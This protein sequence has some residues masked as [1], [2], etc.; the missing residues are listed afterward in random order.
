MKYRGLVPKLILTLSITIC[1]T[2]FIV[3]IILSSLF[4][5]EYYQERLKSLSGEAEV[6]EQVVNSYMKNGST[7][8]ELNKS[9]K[10][11][12]N[13]LNVDIYV[14]DGYGYIYSISNDEYEYLKYTKVDDTEMSS[15]REGK[16]I[17]QKDKKEFV[18]SKPIFN[19]GFFIGAV[20]I[21]TPLSVLSSSL[22]RMN[23]IVWICVAIAIIF[24]S[25][26]IYFISKRIIIKPLNVIN[27]AAKKIANGEIGNRVNLSYDDEVGELA[28]SF[29]IMATSLEEAELNRR[30]FISNVSHELRSPMTSI[31]GFITAILDGVIPRDKEG[32]YLNIVNDEIGRLTRLIN[33]LLDLSAMQAGKLEFNI[34]ELELNRIIETTVLKMKQKAADKNVKI[35][36]VLESDKQYVYGD[37]DRLIQVVTNL[38][39]NAVKY[40]VENGKVKVS[41]KTKGSKVI[42]SIF[43]TSNGISEHDL[44]HIWDRFYKVDKARSNKTSTGLGLSIVRN[45]ILQLE[46]KIWAENVKDKNGEIKGVRFNFTLTKVK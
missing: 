3:G 21:V 14:I 40:C 19:K 43:N 26:A 4:K 1:I 35:E 41:T 11:I 18:Y 44:A 12:A 46:E 24:S 45:I 31:K 7:L 34:S 30:E 42:V 36:V 37:N 25:L 38:V 9:I 8:E 5:E 28:E 22:A 33:D 17:E 6:V 10:F 29:N 32:Y 15:L 2:F 39:D 20:S 16:T 27:N 23:Q 13:S